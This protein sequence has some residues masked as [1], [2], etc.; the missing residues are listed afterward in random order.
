MYQLVFSKKEFKLFLV[1]FVFLGFITSVFGKALPDIK[2]YKIGVDRNCQVKITLGN[3]GNSKIPINR[4][5]NSITMNTYIDSHGKNQLFLKE[6]DPHKY[7]HSVGGS[8]TVQTAQKV[9][10]NKP[11]TI[12]VVFDP[13]N[14]LKEKTKTNN[15]K[16]VR[17]TC[18]RKL[19]DLAAIGMKMEKWS[20]GNCRVYAIIKNKGQGD[21]PLNEFNNAGIRFKRKGF[22][23]NG[24]DLAYLKSKAKPLIHHGRQ[25]EISLP[26]KMG[27]IKANHSARITVLIDESPSF[28][29]ESNKFNNKKTF[30]LRCIN[31]NI[32]VSK[33]HFKPINTKG[34][35]KK[36]IF[37]R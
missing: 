3:V 27:D 36:I 13:N 17:L 11:H 10:P 7:L 32:P 33:S 37:R 19:P 16:T 15:T 29:T 21:I 8:L 5:Y 12:K 18:T 20:N 6:F 23:E 31:L 1:L 14:L 30:T 22:R 35:N 9:V 25:V 2:I 4:L 26:G 28:I 24:Y 34:V